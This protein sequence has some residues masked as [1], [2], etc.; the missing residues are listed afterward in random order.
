MGAVYLASDRRDDQP[1]AL[2]LVHP[3][4]AG[5]PGYRDRF[6]QEAHSAALLRSPYTVKLLDYHR[7][8]GLNTVVFRHSSMYGGRQF[9]TADQG[10]IGWFCQMAAETR[11]L[12]Q[13]VA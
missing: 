5:L 13:A 3:R 8:Y 9:A 7:I 2:K 1:V 12:Y 6:D 4:V 11:T 10:W